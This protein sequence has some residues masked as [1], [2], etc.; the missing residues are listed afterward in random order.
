MVI[1]YEEIKHPLVYMVKDDGYIIWWDDGKN[2]INYFDDLPCN[3]PR[4]TIGSFD[5]VDEA[6]ERFKKMTTDEGW[7]VVE[8]N[9]NDFL[10]VIEYD[11]SSS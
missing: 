10:E 6:L 8:N 2:N 11:K 4:W 5:S 9:L 1:P 3:Y 7:T